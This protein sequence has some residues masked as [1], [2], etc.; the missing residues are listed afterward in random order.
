MGWFIYFVG[1]AAWM[2]QEWLLALG[3][4]SA[5]WIQVF[6]PGILG[7]QGSIQCIPRYS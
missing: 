1:S 7:G 4:L 3:P 6:A 5:T 2:G